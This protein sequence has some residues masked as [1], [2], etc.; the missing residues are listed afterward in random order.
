VFISISM[1]PFGMWRIKKMD[2]VEKVK[3]L[4]Q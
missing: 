4:S 3:D 1:T 2:L